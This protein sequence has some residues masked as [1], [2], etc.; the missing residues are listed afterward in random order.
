MR[1]FNEDILRLVFAFIVTVAGYGSIASSGSVTGFGVG[2]HVGILFKLYIGNNLLLTLLRTFFLALY[3][4][5]KLL[6]KHFFQVFLYLS[7][8]SLIQ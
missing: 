7:Q 3:N 5:S 1:K 6:K 8:N 2:L 4:N